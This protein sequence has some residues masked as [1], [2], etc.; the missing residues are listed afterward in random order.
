MGLIPFVRS[1]VPQAN[2]TV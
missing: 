2:K 1:T